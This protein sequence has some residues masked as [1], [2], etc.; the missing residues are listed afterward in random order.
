M[1][2]IPLG[3]D[4]VFY[5][6]LSPAWA[7]RPTSGAG[8]AERGGRFNRPDV[9]ALYLSVTTET[10]L[11]EYQQDA[12]LLPPGTI[13]SYL[14]NVQRVVDFR[15]GY[16]AGAWDRLWQDYACNWRDLALRHKVE[17][18]SWVLADMAMEAGAQ[19]IFY[20]SVR[21]LGGYNIAV[22][23]AAVVEPDELRVHDPEGH[24]AGEKNRQGKPAA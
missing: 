12:G 3:P 16:V 18:P 20:P 14:L 11:Q 19:A 4:A 24:L 9:H 21:H 17:P 6:V 1:I 8:A 2:F 5:R 15:A 7:H 23:L 22:F 10:A 13:A